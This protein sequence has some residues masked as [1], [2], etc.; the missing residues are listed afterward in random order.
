MRHSAGF[1]KW[2]INGTWNVSFPARLPETHEKQG[3][4]RSSSGQKWDIGRRIERYGIG[5][6][7]G[8][9]KLDHSSILFRRNPPVSRIWSQISPKHGDSCLGANR[10]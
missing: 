8:H 5:T 9:G 10:T 2:D 4:K 1:D 7:M 6:K 3:F